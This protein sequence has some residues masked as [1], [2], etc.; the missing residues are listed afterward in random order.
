MMILPFHLVLDSPLNTTWF[1][2][3]EMN[4]DCDIDFNRLGN[5]LEFVFV[6]T[7]PLSY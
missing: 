6:K 2:P 1:T 7:I 3:N 4:W 5:I